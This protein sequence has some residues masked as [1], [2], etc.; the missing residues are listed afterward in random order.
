MTH[1][2]QGE[3]RTPEPSRIL[4]RLCYHF[5]RKIDVRYDLHEGTAQFPWGRCTMRAGNDVL[6]FECEACDPPA[7][8]RV[9]HV[10][11][12]HIALFSRKQPLSVQ[13][14]A[15]AGDG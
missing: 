4:Q 13:W 8:E 14:Q 2:L 5:S 3:T 7:L 1:T 6:H 15:T 12:E 9:R 10:I 11:D